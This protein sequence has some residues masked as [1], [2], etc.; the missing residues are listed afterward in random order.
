M[1]QNL[2]ATDLCFE[3][4]QPAATSSKTRAGY[5]V[6]RPCGEIVYA[7]CARCQMLIPL[8]EMLWREETRCC[9]DCFAKPEPDAQAELL[10][11]EELATLLA[12]FTR[13]HAE[14]KQLSKQL[15]AI[16]E[17]LKRHAATQPR[18]NNAVLLR[19]GE[20]G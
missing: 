12:D 7:A 14:E 5:A 19:A 6:C 17:R 8:D 1:K 16:K 11:E 20:A 10:S 13:L 4:L 2:V 18:I 9:P 15:E 3:C